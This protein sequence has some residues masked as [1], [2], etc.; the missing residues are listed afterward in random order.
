MKWYKVRHFQKLKHHSIV[1]QTWQKY[2]FEEWQKVS[3]NPDTYDLNYYKEYVGAVEIYTL[4]E[5]DERTTGIR[6]V[7]AFPKTIGGIPLGHSSNNTN[8]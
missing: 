7:E 6:L 5:K 1:G 8:K 4:N 2:F 3:Y